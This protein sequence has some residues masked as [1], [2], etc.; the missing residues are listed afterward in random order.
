MK[1]RS[2]K[3]AVFKVGNNDPRFTVNVNSTANK[4]NIANFSDGGDGIRVVKGEA[5]K[6]EIKKEVDLTSKRHQGV[7]LTSYGWRK[8][9]TR[10]SRKIIN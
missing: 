10:K 6:K 3:Q 1:C 2:V 5:K 4:D 8:Q 9:R 7:N